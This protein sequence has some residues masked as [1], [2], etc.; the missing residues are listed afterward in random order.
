M[1][2]EE[3]YE[4][5]REDFGRVTLRHGRGYAVTLRDGT[6][7]TLRAIRWP[8][9]WT[10]GPERDAPPYA[11]QDPGAYSDDLILEVLPDGTFEPA[12]G[13]EPLDSDPADGLLREG[14]TVE[15]PVPVDDRARA[16]W[17]ALFGNPTVCPPLRHVV[18]EPPSPPALPHRRRGP[19]ARDP[20]PLGLAHARGPV[21]QGVGACSWI[22]GR[23]GPWRVRRA[24][25]HRGYRGQRRPGHVDGPD[26]RGREAGRRDG[27]RLGSSGGGDCDGDARLDTSGASDVTGDGENKRAAPLPHG[28][29]AQGDRC[30]GRA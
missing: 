10:P 9:D 29:G 25:Q 20:R 6:R 17:A 11:F 15:N 14:L 23:A 19:A 16:V 12:S 28:G 3:L 27:E 2:T 22:P 24:A 4:F 13:E 26:V 7:V 8:H 21:R 18:G 5:F 30:D 1:T